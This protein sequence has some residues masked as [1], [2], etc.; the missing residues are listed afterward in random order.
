VTK[1]ENLNKEFG[2]WAGF[3]AAHIFPLGLQSQWQAQGW[4]Q[5]ITI[6]PPKRSYGSINSVQNG[7][8]L[9]SDIHEL[10]DSYH[11]SINPDVSPLQ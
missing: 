6:L 3:Q 10:F 2:I 8:L 11:F 4:S 1:E 9:R 7:L 5:Q